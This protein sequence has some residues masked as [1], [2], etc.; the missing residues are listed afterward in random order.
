MKKVVVWTRHDNFGIGNTLH[1]YCSSIQ[2][3]LLEDRLFI[4]NSVVIEKFCA[5]V[6]C[7]LLK[8]PAPGYKKGPS[9]DMTIARAFQYSFDSRK[10]DKIDPFDPFY[11]ISGCLQPPRTNIEDLMQWPRFC[12]YSKLVRNLVRG[13][14]GGRLEESKKWLKQCVIMIFK[15]FTFIIII[16]ELILK[17]LKVLRGRC[18]KI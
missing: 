8:L 7:R 18:K 3:A 14:M 9:D 16:Q 12:I 17:I 10:K 2:D 6:S 1:G 15:I 11:N 5:I 4:V 13:G